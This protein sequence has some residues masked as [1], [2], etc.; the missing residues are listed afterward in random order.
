MAD[1]I[2]SRPFEITDDQLIENAPRVRALLIQ[3]Y[4][5]IWDRVEARIIVDRGGDRPLDPRFL[6]IGLRALKEESLLYRLNR[7][8][9][10]AEEEEEISG[11]TDRVELV[12]KQLAEVE[13]RINKAA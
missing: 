13:A 7:A 3:R 2:G 10:V 8:V 12:L 6:E 5:E 9:P 4:E 1:A 11:G